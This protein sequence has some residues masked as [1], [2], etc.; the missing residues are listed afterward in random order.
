[1]IYGWDHPETARRYAAFCAAHDR[2]AAA[3]RRLV[4]EAGIGPGARVL[5][6]AAGTGETAKTVLSGVDV[7]GIVCVEPAAAMR[8]QCGRSL[9]DPRVVWV[10]GLAEATPPFDA[11]LC[12][13]A[14]WQLAPLGQTFAALAAKLLPGARLAF[15]IPALY[16]GQPDDPGGGADPML[17]E[18]MARL[19]QGRTSSAGEI[20]PLPDPDGID[21]L[22]R[23]AG[24]GDIRQWHHDEKLSQ[25][26][27]RDWLKIPPI[28]DALLGDLEAHARADLIDEAY[29]EV[30]AT[31]WRWE[32]WAGWTAVKGP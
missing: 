31:S 23:E 14:M 10:A 15:N 5:D 12:G 1:M 25:A 32:R 3:N 16:L 17:T 6:I 27:W 24:F 9:E 13:A 2:Y 8:D 11:V 22:L 21:T 19:A 18:L 20:D 30:D 4:A 29:A 7:G 28:T 26:A